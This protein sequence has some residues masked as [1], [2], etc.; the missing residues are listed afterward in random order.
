MKPGRNQNSRSVWSAVREGLDPWNMATARV[1]PEPNVYSTG[2]G[3]TPLLG[4][5]K[6]PTSNIQHP[7]S[8]ERKRRQ[9]CSPPAAA[10]QTLRDRP[11]APQKLV[12]VATWA[13]GLTI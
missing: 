10:L 12:R 4:K 3:H 7:T 1:Q 13:A 9:P 6:H 11:V 5:G 8:N 2:R